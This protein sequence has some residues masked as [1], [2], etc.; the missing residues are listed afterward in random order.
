[1][2]VRIS[3]IDLAASRSNSGTVDCF[4]W[5]EKDDCQVGAKPTYL[6]LFLF[7]KSIEGLFESLKKDYR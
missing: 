2:R 4:R 3:H 7:G 6:F 1:M 5:S